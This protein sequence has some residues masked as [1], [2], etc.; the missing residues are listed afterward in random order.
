MVTEEILFHIT[1]NNHLNETNVDD[2]TAVVKE[3]PFFSPAQFLL[4]LKQ[5]K[6]NSY[7]FE[8][9][10]Q[11]A[12]LYFSNQVWLNYLLA[13]K[14]ISTPHLQLTDVEPIVQTNPEI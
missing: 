13:D 4:A 2:I 7:N 10:L 5:K 8:Y 6:D 11:K 12:S 9:Q 3:Y 14:E 1:G